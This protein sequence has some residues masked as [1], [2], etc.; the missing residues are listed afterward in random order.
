MKRAVEQLYSDLGEKGRFPEFLES[1]LSS[2]IAHWEQRGG[3]ADA[4]EMSSLAR[5]RTI[6]GILELCKDLNKEKLHRR[7]G[8]KALTFFEDLWTE[9]FK[10]MDTRVTKRFLREITDI[11]SSVRD[12]ERERLYQDVYQVSCRR[13]C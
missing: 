12:Y 10:E 5:E 4:S 11:A 6:R 13:D 2:W 1:L 3:G 7:F 8:K 9:K